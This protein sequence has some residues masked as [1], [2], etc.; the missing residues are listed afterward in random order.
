MDTLSPKGGVILA[1]GSLL[2]IVCLHI[3]L[4][5]CSCSCVLMCILCILYH[6]ASD[7]TAVM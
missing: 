6:C 1:F 3:G 2:L 5:M 4:H 7:M